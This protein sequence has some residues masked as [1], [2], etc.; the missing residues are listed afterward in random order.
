MEEENQE[1]AQDCQPDRGRAPNVGG[2][3]NWSMGASHTSRAETFFDPGGEARIASNREVVPP[4]DNRRPYWQRFGERLAWYTI[5]GNRFWPMNARN[6]VL[7]AYLIGKV[8]GLW[9]ESLIALLPWLLFAGAEAFA[10]YQ[11]WHLYQVSPVPVVQSIIFLASF[12]II[13]PFVQLMMVLHLQRMSRIIPFE[14]LSLTRLSDDELFYGLIIRPFAIQ[15]AY[16]FAFMLFSSFATIIVG[17][18]NASFLYR[19]NT[20]YEDIFIVIAIMLVYYIVRWGVFCLAI[21]LA[22]AF[23]ARA[24]LFILSASGAFRRMLRD[25]LLIGGGFPIYLPLLPF[26]VTYLAIYWGACLTCLILIPATYAL[27]VIMIG[28][29]KVPTRVMRLTAR[30]S[31]YWWARTRMEPE[32]IPRIAKDIW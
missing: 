8:R 4:S 7:Q 12:L 10:L 30:Y 21:N 19:Q 23:A 2:I 1:S 16:N 9:I 27:L 32:D 18:Q 11:W 20:K 26:A 14:E 5:G 6:N 31:K 17:Y 28:L 24:R 25:Y 3:A 15:H 13:G 29:T 22:V